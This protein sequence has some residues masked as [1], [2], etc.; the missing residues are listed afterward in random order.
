ME[1]VWQETNRTIKERS[2]PIDMII[3]LTQ[4]CNLNCCHCYNVKNRS[5]L[6]FAQIKEILKQLREAGCLFITLTGGEVFARDDFLEIAAYIRDSGFDISIFTNGTLITPKIAEEL[7]Q[8][9]PTGVGISIHSVTPAIHDRITGVE[10]SFERSLTGI[11]LLKERGISVHLKCNLMQENFDQYNQI[12]QLAKSLG[13]FYVIDPVVSPKD[14]GSKAVLKHRLTNEQMEDVFMEQFAEMEGM[15][16][17]AR[18]E[19][20]CDAGRTFGSISVTGDVYPC[21]QVPLKAGN[22]FER[23]FKDIWHDSEILNKIR[24]VKRED[25]RHCA[26]CQI[27]EYCFRCPGLA[28]LEDGDLL[29]PSSVACFGAGL[30]KR[31]QE[32]KTE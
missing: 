9:S 26:D 4:R 15:Q 1:D 28:Y 11:K 22:I 3:E 20:F 30:N 31:L 32:K 2:I 27:A 7:E 13:I 24:K 17:T 8:L 18:Q 16:Q 29:G 21:I 14:D 23:R 12:I 19:F 25:I 10:G 5:Q 6:D